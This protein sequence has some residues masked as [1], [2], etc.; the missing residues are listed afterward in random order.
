MRLN[1]TSRF[2]DSI[3]N[4]K[5]RSTCLCAKAFPYA[6]LLWIWTLFLTIL[7]LHLHL[8]FHQQ[9][10]SRTT[11]TK[12]HVF[13]T[14]LSWLSSHTIKFFI[15]KPALDTIRPLYGGTSGSVNNLGPLHSLRSNWSARCQYTVTG[16]GSC[17]ELSHVWQHIICLGFSLGSVLHLAWIR[18]QDVKLRGFALSMDS[19]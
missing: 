16:W 17:F 14:H 2:S 8:H 5:Y 12:T 11:K 15:D 19:E 7:L 4:K 18:I 13:A 9:P 6:V 10:E 3:S 1:I